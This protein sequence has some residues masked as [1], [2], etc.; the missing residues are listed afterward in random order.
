MMGTLSL[1]SGLKI[2]AI[3]CALFLAACDVERTKRPIKFSS[4]YWVGYE[5]F[6]VAEEMSFY[7]PGAVHLIETPISVTLQE[8]LWAKSIDAVAVSLTRALYLADQGHDIVIVAVLDWSNGADKLLASPTIKTVADLKGA[9][10]AAEP[11]TVN[12]YL[13]HRALELYGLEPNDI[14]VAPIYN[15]DTPDAYREGTI[16]AAAVFGHAVDRLKG[17]GAHSIFDSSQTPGEIIDVL[18]VRRSY[19][20]ENEYRVIQLID[21]WLKGAE[22]L[23]NLPAGQEAPI[24]LLKPEQLKNSSAGVTFAGIDE[25]KHFFKNGAEKLQKIQEKRQAFIESETGKRLK[26]PLISSTPFD[27]VLRGLE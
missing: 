16:Q 9:T 14:T 23:N 2:V 15:D 17:L 6:F 10:V 26:L 11:E 20:M 3:I 1:R 8:A 13:L 4:K 7:D 5:P 27:Y 24:G 18:V 19:L 21:G 22:Y 12:S 25:N